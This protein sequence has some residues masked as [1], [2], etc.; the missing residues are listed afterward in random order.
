MI[1]ENEQEVGVEIRFGNHTL[2]DLTPQVRQ[3]LSAHA[4]ELI[5]RLGYIGCIRL[6]IGAVVQSGE[7]RELI[8]P[9]R[10][11]P[12]YGVLVLIRLHQFGRKITFR[13]VLQ[14][15]PEVSCEQLF[16]ELVEL[17]SPTRFA[18]LKRTTGPTR[19]E[20]REARALYGDCE[21]L[22]KE[23]RIT[24]MDIIASVVASFGTKMF[25]A[26]EIK[27]TMDDWLGGALSIKNLDSYIRLM[28]Q[29][30]LAV[31]AGRRR[32]RPTAKAARVAE[33]CR[34]RMDALTQSVEK[35]IEEQFPPS[36]SLDE[37]ELLAL[38]A[39]YFE[40]QSEDELIRREWRKALS[41]EQEVA[42]RIAEL[43]E[44]LRRHRMER[45]RQERRMNDLDRATAKF[46]LAQ[47]IGRLRQRTKRVAT[48][49]PI[50]S[51]A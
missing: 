13:G 44:T 42:L 14:R 30:G 15:P 17:L 31:A 19:A 50:P 33:A 5:A 26:D 7:D 8:R 3:V 46:E 2:E 16:E 41:K 32:Y 40:A 37:G 22:S 34:I 27:S 49:E 25:T 23:H 35:I 39:E 51:L 6:Q 48:N 38:E 45:E 18:T 9:V 29:S 10:P 36:A 47:R 24:A 12:P 1:V 11:D 28:I 21:R 4:A 20:V 43:E